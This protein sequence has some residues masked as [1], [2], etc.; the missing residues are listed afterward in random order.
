MQTL[1]ELMTFDLVVPL[2]LL[3]LSYGAL[4]WVRHVGRKLDKKHSKQS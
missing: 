4:L 3:A 2:L 1:Q